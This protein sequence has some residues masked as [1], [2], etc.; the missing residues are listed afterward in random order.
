MLKLLELLHC[1]PGITWNKFINAV[2]HP[3]RKS[4]KAGL[5]PIS[6]SIYCKRRKNAELFSGM[7]Y[8]FYVPLAYILHLLESC[9]FSKRTSDAH[10][11][12]PINKRP[13]TKRSHSPKVLSREK[14]AVLQAPLY[15]L[16]YSTTGGGGRGEDMTSLRVHS[17]LK[18]W[19]RLLGKN[20]LK[21]GL[22]IDFEGE[23]VKIFCHNW[24]LDIIT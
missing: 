2:F 5:P 19:S 22:R 3:N 17:I 4:E 6:P 15:L 24:N 7:R 8:T 23:D 16:D 9:R 21:N 13:I 1:H 18:K 20:E 14:S 11:E 10:K 12:R